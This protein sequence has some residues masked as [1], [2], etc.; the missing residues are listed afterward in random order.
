[1]RHVRMLGLCLVAALAIGA[2]MVSSASAL[3]EWGK[4][5]A[6]TGGK[7]KD[8]NCTEPAK[9]GTGAYEW[10]K[11]KTLPNMK[12][13]GN[14]VGSGGVLSSGLYLCSSSNESV[15]ERR[16]TNK[17][18]EE[19]EG[20]VAKFIEAKIECETEHNTGEA[21]GAKDVTN[22]SVRFRGCKLFG[23]DPC[24]NGPEAGE[25]QV[26]PLKGELGYINKAEKKVGIV[27][28]PKTKK[29]AFAS[30]NCAGI[31]FDGRRCRQLERRRL[32]LARKQGRLRR[33]HLA[34]HSGEQD[35]PDV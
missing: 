4:C 26:N 25:I 18:C 19:H 9:R 8:A 2:V 13:S 10:H 7:Y 32:V 16:V 21:T 34:D 23:T 15:R 14:N 33:D 20:T 30:F 17:D 3:P 27:L 6:K 12:F 22:I 11:G 31:L 28:E 35:D 29:G 1:M 24:S 5:E